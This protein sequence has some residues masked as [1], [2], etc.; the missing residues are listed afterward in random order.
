MTTQN[1]DLDGLQSFT[2]S[3]VYC[4]SEIAIDAVK[5]SACSSFQ[6]WRRHLGLWATLISL[7]LGAVA[8]YSLMK[9]PINFLF[10][11][12]YSV[13]SLK[14]SVTSKSYTV[15]IKNTG[16]KAFS[17]N[18]ASAYILAANDHSDRYFY[19]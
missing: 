6:N 17:V 9:E 19:V 18:S 11:K 16:R 2:L 1:R 5:C 13:R 3:C 15:Q 8:T 12:E 10:K 14:V 7:F 4:K